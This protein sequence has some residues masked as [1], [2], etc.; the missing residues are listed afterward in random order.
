MRIL[1]LVDFW[2]F[3]DEYDPAHTSLSL[4]YQEAS[5]NVGPE[6]SH[7]ASTVLY[8]QSEPLIGGALLCY[9]HL[10]YSHIGAVVNPAAL[11]S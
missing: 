10:C 4:Y 3:E 7:R 9:S 8:S 1:F 11:V 6:Y 2:L 5:G